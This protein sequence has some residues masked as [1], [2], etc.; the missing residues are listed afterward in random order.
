MQNWPGLSSWLAAYNMRL[1]MSQERD[2][3]WLWDIYKYYIDML[4]KWL[5]GYVKTNYFSYRFGPQGHFA[6]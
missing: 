2:D 6:L 5:E 1:Q 3:E 4:A